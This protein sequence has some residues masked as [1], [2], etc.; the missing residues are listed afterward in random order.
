MHKRL[1]LT[2]LGTNALVLSDTITT[3]LVDPHFT[4]PAG[5]FGP[6]ILLKH[7]KPDKMTIKAALDR[8][9]V[10]DAQAVL[11]THTH[12]DHALDAVDTA[13]I[14]GAC[15][16]GSS[17]LKMLPG[18]DVLLKNRLITAEPLTHYQYGEFSVTFLQSRH[19]PMP[20][21]SQWTAFA[22]SHLTKPLIPPVTALSYKEGDVFNILIEHPSGSLYI[23][24]TASA[25]TDS[26]NH[27]TDYAGISVGGL[28]LK[29]AEYIRCYLES[30]RNKLGSRM[31]ILTHWDNFSQPLSAP[32]V[33]MPGMYR[34]YKVI[35]SV[36][37]SWKP[38]VKVLKPI[39][40][41]EIVL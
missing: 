28:N 30:C 9:G 25:I 16:I 37:S 17:S 3:L 7:I 27:N 19:L 20:L 31:L 2:Y 33:D 38:G 18:A 36:T 10:R 5:L 12:Y 4:R 34:V 40:F 1:T 14:T 32:A 24:G 41:D 15:L 6:A 23:L 39:I 8:A 35:N 29:S 13:L 22:G 11:I 26:V 21:V